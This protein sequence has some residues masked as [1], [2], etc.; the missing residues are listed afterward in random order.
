MQLTGKFK[1]GKEEIKS[2][3]GVSIN[4]DL[5]ICIICTSFYKLHNYRTEELNQILV[6]T[7]NEM[8]RYGDTCRYVINNINQIQRQQL[9]NLLFLGKTAIVG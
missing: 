7:R 2:E 5:K 4:K 1:N 6:Y 3:L 8:E 9:G